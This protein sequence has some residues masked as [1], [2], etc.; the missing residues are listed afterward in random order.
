MS[1]HKKISRANNTQT[2][3]LS[4]MKGSDMMLLLHKVK[5]M[6]E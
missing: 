4:E 5:N 6:K 2:V 3:D 1:K